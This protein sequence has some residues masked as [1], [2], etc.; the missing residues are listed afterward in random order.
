MRSEIDG[1]DPILDRTQ[2]YEARMRVLFHW[3][4]GEGTAAFSALEIE[5]AAA[6]PLERHSDSISAV[7]FGACLLISAR[8]IVICASIIVLIY[9]EL[10][11]DGSNVECCWVGVLGPQ[12]REQ[13]RSALSVPRFD[14]KHGNKRL[15]TKRNHTCDSLLQL[16]GESRKTRRLC[17]LYRAAFYN[18]G[19]GLQI[20]LR[21]TIA[22]SMTMMV[23]KRIILSY[24]IYRFAAICNFLCFA[25]DIVGIFR[26][27]SW[28]F[29]M[30]T[31]CSTAR[32]GSC[33]T[34]ASTKSCRSL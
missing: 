7:T 10:T 24:S 18:H 33:G 19:P 4:T 17:P 27:T 3:T 5:M 20:R 8:D 13:I 9:S 25:L 6:S 15:T 23:S 26:V 1:I 28:L 30:S 32:R 29:C 34:T 22:M 16:L 11:S 21:S 31:A 2:R 12:H 14:G